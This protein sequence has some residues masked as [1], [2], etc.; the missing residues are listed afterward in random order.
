VSCQATV[1]RGAAEVEP[2]KDRP[3]KDIVIWG[4]ISLATDLLKKGVIDEVQL[5]VVP[6]ALGSGRQLFDEEL[7]HS[8]M[9]LVEA[10]PHG[11]GLVL[12]RYETSH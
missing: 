9:N 12:L 6:V 3:G 7:P 2:L 5:R 11:A 4:S 8:A 1:I 10:R